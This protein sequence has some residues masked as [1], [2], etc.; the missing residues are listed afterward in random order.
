MLSFSAAV[1]Q[2][3][4]ARRNVVSGS[5]CRHR[6]PLDDNHDALKHVRSDSQGALLPHSVRRKGRSLG[7]PVFL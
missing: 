2:T 1:S 3:E 5:F 6:P 4:E 7:L